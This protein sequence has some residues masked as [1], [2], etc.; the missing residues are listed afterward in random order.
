MVHLR[1]SLECKLK[2]KGPLRWPLKTQQLLNILNLK[3]NFQEN[4]RSCCVNKLTEEVAWSLAELFRLVQTKYGRRCS[5]RKKTQSNHSILIINLSMNKAMWMGALY[6]VSYRSET[7]IMSLAYYSTFVSN[8][9]KIS[10]SSM[11]KRRLFQRFISIHHDI[12]WENILRRNTHTKRHCARSIFSSR[13]A[14][15]VFSSFSFSCFI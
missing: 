13:G 8:R 11:Q 14:R 4:L 3:S 9:S 5:G 10:R 6:S 12:V 7:H 1:T 15:T 2:G